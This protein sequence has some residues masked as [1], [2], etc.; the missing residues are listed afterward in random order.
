ML[1]KLLFKN[2]DKKQLVIAII[3]AFMGITFLITSIH[4]IVKVNDFGSYLVSKTCTELKIKLIH[5]S[6][7]EAYGTARYSTMKETHPLLPTTI[8]ASSKAASES[9]R[10][11]TRLNSSH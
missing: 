3:G 10:K 1:S 9:D 7:S 8:Y 4:Y 2:Q 5:V 11:S 6:S